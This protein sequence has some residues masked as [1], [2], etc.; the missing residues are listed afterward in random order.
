M[1]LGRCVLFARFIPLCRT[2]FHLDIAILSCGCSLK[3]LCSEQCIIV[4]IL[5]RVLSALFPVRSGVEGS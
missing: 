2:G 3:R 4:L 1:P 5:L